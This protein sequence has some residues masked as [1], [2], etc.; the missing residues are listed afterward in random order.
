MKSWRRLARGLGMALALGVSTTACLDADDNRA[1]TEAV[2]ERSFENPEALA[3]AAAHWHDLFAEAARGTPEARIDVMQRYLN[4]VS[5][6]EAGELAEHYGLDY[7]RTDHMRMS[8]VTQLA[9]VARYHEAGAELNLLMR[10]ASA[11]VP[12]SR[13]A[14]MKAMTE[15]EMSPNG[16]VLANPDKIPALR[17]R[18][19]EA[20]RDHG[21]DEWADALDYRL[22]ILAYVSGDMDDAAARTVDEARAIARAPGAVTDVLK[23]QTLLHIAGDAL[24]AQGR[25]DE[26]AAM[27]AAIEALNPMKAR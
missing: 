13:L 15:L 3:G 16:D 1:P 10:S 23:A 5:S 27:D 12:R 21:A 18:L 7:F 14:Y 19:L 25:F 22:A 9:A 8:L 4:T 17:A 6:T 2:Q 26:R 20:E 24:A 11:P